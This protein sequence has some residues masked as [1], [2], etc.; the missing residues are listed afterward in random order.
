[1]P[2]YVWYAAYGSNL[3]SERLLTYLEG[4]RFG[5]NTW[6]HPGARDSSPPLA[7]RAD[8]LPHQL[9][10]ARKSPA[11]NKGGVAFL[12]PRR[13]AAQQTLGRLWKVTAQQFEDIVRQE[14]RDPELTIPW[15]TIADEPVV[16]TGWYGR[17]L[18]LGTRDEL[19]VLTCTIDD[20]GISGATVTPDESYLAAL[21][22]GLHETYHLGRQGVAKYLAGCPGVSGTWSKNRLMKLWDTVCSVP[23]EQ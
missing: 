19:P 23:E 21:V 15:D 11:W 13:D 8:F 18:H 2:E 16:G 9:V 5:A 14:N 10:F 4:G 6:N 22:A 1:M 17:L 7:E 3:F 12:H 20:H